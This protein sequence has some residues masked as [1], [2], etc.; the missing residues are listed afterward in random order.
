MTNKA[1][2]IKNFFF[3]VLV[4]FN[5]ATLK[6]Q[7]NWY[8]PTWEDQN[9]KESHQNYQ[10]VIRTIENRLEGNEA[11]AGYSRQF[12]V[13]TAVQIEKSLKAFEIYYSL[14]NYER[15]V[16]N[17]LEELIKDTS[18]TNHIDIRFKRSPKLEVETHENG[19]ILLNVG[20]ISLLKNE[21]E[22]AL[23]L[24]HEIA[25]FQNNDRLRRYSQLIYASHSTEKRIP[26]I[27]PDRLPEA[28]S[29]LLFSKGAE[30]QADIQAMNTVAAS[31]FSPVLALDVLRTMEREVL[32]DHLRKGKRP[33]PWTQHPYL[34]ERLNYLN[35]AWNDTVA[36]GNKSFKVDKTSFKGLKAL[37]FQET[38]NWCIENGEFDL[39]MT[40]SFSQYLLHPE[41]SDNLAVLIEALRRKLLT[42]KGSATQRF[43]LSQY[44]SGLQSATYNY[45]VV[46]D[47]QRSI[48]HGLD[49]GLLDLWSTDITDST[50]GVLADT[51][52]IEFR[53]NEEAFRYFKTIAEQYQVIQARHYRFFEPIWDFRDLD[54]FLNTNQVFTTAAYLRDRGKPKLG[55]SALAILL[56]VSDYFAE[57]FHQLTLSDMTLMNDLL[58]NAVE[59]ELKGKIKFVPA[60]GLNNRSRLLLKSL[61]EVTVADLEKREPLLNARECADNWLALHPEMYPLFAERGIYYLYLCRVVSVSEIETSLQ[62]FKISIPGT[63]KSSQLMWQAEYR[64]KTENDRHLPYTAVAKEFARF[65]YLFGKR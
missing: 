38:V 61:V 35:T 45:A 13:W 15:Y 19:L 47:P 1:K 2:K 8:H 14:Q 44:E 49:L 12:A 31:V 57:A 18:L 42:D 51:S 41:D 11:A 22:L 9:W 64:F 36:R 50:A 59:A 39:L 53:T 58:K 32:R 60:S 55:D 52:K 16:K 21:A 30:V 25:H 24:A 17:V 7:T 43:I 40:R 5:V 63:A 54:A 37:C 6:T 23:V 4:V 33:E 62:F 20:L 34:T 46:K 27:G 10:T 28:Q 65:I 29:T 56:P 48:L 26:G 3:T